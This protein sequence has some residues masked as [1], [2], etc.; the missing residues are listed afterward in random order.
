VHLQNETSKRSDL[1]YK[2][3]VRRTRAAAGDAVKYEGPGSTHDLEV[4][5]RSGNS[6]DALNKVLVAS[7]AFQQSTS[8]N[9]APAARMRYV[10]TGGLI[11]YSATI[12][13]AYQLSSIKAA[14]RCGTVGRGA[15]TICRRD[16]LLIVPSPDRLITL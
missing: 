16:T 7:G 9:V 8:S 4:C 14:S 1:L 12:S 13:C 3:E 6:L 11:S 2:I 15:G 10:V 5:S